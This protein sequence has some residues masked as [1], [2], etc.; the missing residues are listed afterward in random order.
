[1]VRL[2]IR[3]G[4]C[5]WFGQPSKLAVGL[6]RCGHVRG[7]LWHWRWCWAGDYRSGFSI[8]ET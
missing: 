7:G 2:N 3:W 4:G 8:P 1:M 5:R 6:S